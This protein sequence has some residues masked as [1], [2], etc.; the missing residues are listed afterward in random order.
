MLSKVM[1][2]PHWPHAVGQLPY[3]LRVVVLK[4]CVIHSQSMASADE[5]QIAPIH[6]MLTKRIL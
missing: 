3:L 5:V 2:K 4:V 1:A 6:M